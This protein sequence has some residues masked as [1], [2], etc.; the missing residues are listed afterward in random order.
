MKS[1]TPKN[2][3]KSKM[4]TGRTRMKNDRM[5]RKI[6]RKITNSNTRSGVVIT[7]IS[8]RFLIW[9]LVFTFGCIL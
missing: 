5:I 6:F 2:Q 9:I 3:N 7:M 4:N 1:K 8:S